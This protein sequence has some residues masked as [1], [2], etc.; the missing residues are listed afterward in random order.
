MNGH[1]WMESNGPGKGA[2]CKFIVMLK[3]DTEGEE[4]QKNEY[5]G[6]GPDVNFFAL[7]VSPVPRVPLFCPSLGLLSPAPLSNPS[8]Q[9]IAPCR[10]L[11]AFV[12]RCALVH[13]HATLMLAS[14]SSMQNLRLQRWQGECVLLLSRAGTESMS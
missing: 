11:I 7:R 4:G 1:I 14:L 9:S 3:L 6:D 2:T 8:L 10:H 5:E 13:V 12:A